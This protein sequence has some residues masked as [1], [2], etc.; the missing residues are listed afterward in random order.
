L[1][2]DLARRLGGLPSSVVKLDNSERAGTVRL[3]TLRRA[4]AAMDCELVVLVVPQQPLQ[5]SVA[6]QRLKLFSATFNRAATHIKLEGQAVSEGQHRHLLQQAE[7]E[8]PDT[9]L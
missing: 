9:A 2:S 6:Q 1:I 5:S 8:T 3:E 4:A 7:V